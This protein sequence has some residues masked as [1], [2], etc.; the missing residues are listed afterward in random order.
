[1]SKQYFFIGLFIIG[2]FVQ[3]GE[4]PVYRQDQ[5]LLSGWELNNT[6]RFTLPENGNAPM[7]VYVHLRNDQ[8]YPFANIF[9][10]ISVKEGD[11]LRERDTLEYAMAKPNGEWLGTGFSSVKESRLEWKKNWEYNGETP[12]VVEIAQ[13]NRTNGREKAAEVLPGILSVGLSVELLEE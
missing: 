12:P 2:F 1:M 3:C 10:I 7:D 4:T 9:L 11:S 13:A 8:N 6:L 5:N